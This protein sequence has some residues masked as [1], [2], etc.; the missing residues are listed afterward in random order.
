[1]GLKRDPVSES[2]LIDNLNMDLEYNDSLR[3]SK[4][5][6]KFVA[7]KTPTSSA[8]PLPASMFFTFKFFTFT[9]CQTESVALHTVDSQIKLGTQ[10][11]LVLPDTLRLMK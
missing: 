3:A 11:C 5:I 8:A 7:F 9:A 10:Y 6:L 2:R 1:M 4:I